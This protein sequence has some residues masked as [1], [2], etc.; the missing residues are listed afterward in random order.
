MLQNLKNDC[1]FS[2]KSHCSSTLN[3]DYID[4]TDIKIQEFQPNNWIIIISART[5]VRK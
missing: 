3:L 5:D 2:R 1:E 4:E